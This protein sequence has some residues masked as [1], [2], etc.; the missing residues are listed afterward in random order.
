MC[1]GAS[2]NDEER[3]RET[4]FTSLFKYILLEPAH[5]VPRLTQTMSI[6]PLTTRAS[7]RV[8]PCLL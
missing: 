1:F 2:E 8:S 4:F 5:G 7:A 3:R 6:L